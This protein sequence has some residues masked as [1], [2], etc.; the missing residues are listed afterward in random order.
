MLETTFF[1]LSYDFYPGSQIFV[2]LP[3]H[4][5]FDERRSLG[6]SLLQIAN[7]CSFFINI[8]YDFIGVTE[9]LILE[10]SLKATH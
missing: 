7:T 2:I 1:K 9:V 10:I 5:H 6:T 3:F 8:G 4:P